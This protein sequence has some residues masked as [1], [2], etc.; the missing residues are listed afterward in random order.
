MEFTTKEA[1]V[2]QELP[3]RRERL[4]GVRVLIAEDNELNAEISMI[5]LEDLGMKV[6]KTP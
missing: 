5:Q 1:A 3:Q 2:K 6:C 4:N